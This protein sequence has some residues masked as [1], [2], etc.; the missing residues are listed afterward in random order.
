MVRVPAQV[1]GPIPPCISQHMADWQG[2]PELH[3]QDSLSQP[4]SQD[5][6]SQYSLATA[7]GPWGP[8][9]RTRAVP[10]SS[11]VSWRLPVQSIL[12][13][14]QLLSQTWPPVIPAPSALFQISALPFVL[15][16]TELPSPSHHLQDDGLPSLYSQGQPGHKRSHAPSE[17]H[18]GF[19]GRPSIKSLSAPCSCGTLGNGCPC[20][21]RPQ[22]PSPEYEDI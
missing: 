4:A 14:S 22:S 21:I 20:L 16:P 11:P 7:G 6:Q 1:T 3:L 15:L 19:R 12:C 18:S 10:R 9:Q 2:T 13:T 17:C 5:P 8:L